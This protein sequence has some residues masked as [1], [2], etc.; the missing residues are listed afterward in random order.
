MTWEKQVT[1]YKPF[2]I[3]TPKF[4]FMKSKTFYW[5][6]LLFALII[7]VLVIYIVSYS[8]F[9]KY[10]KLILVFMIPLIFGYLMGYCVAKI[11]SD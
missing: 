4:R 3:H 5:V 8:D 6:A 9:N 10:I 7:P 11:S 1:S 2:K